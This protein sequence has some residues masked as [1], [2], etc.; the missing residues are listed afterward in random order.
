MSSSTWVGTRSRLAA[1]SSAVEP[2]RLR[3]PAVET[4]RVAPH[5]GVTVR[6]DGG[7]DLVDDRR[8]GLVVLCALVRARGLLERLHNLVFLSD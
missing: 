8:D 6:G 1:I 4:G 7:D 2:E 5:G 3:L